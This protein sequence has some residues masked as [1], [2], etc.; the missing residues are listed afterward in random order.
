MRDPYLIL[1]HGEYI[2]H[3]IEIQI[4]SN[5][6]EIKLCM[7]NWNRNSWLDF[8]P[9]RTALNLPVKASIFCIT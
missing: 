4:A 5:C 3:V 7:N 1:M 8:I 2:Y 6:Y 9:E